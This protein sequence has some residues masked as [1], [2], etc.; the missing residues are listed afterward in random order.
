LPVLLAA[1]AARS[2]ALD[3]VVAIIAAWNLRVLK[4]PGAPC[5]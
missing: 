2:V 5:R 1:R 3:F 4:Q